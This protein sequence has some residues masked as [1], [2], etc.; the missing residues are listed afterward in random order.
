MLYSITKKEG[1]S[2][3]RVCVEVL[4]RENQSGFRKGRGYTDQIY[5]LRVLMEE[6]KQESINILCMHA[7]LTYARY[8]IPSTEACFGQFSN[9]VTIYHLSSSTL[10][11]PCTGIPLQL[12]DP[13]A[14]YLIVSPYQL[15]SNRFVCLHQLCST[16]SLILWYGLPSVTTQVK[17]WV[18][19]FYWMQT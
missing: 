11:K 9:T 17:V 2:S 3:K 10:S 18:C 7:L 1:W 15:V 4:L 16:C 8:M 12:W 5:S 13:M 19:P 6:L 14:R